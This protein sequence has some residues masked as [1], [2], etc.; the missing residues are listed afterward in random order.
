MEKA[1]ELGTVVPRKI[2]SLLL[3]SLTCIFR[4]KLNR[5]MQLQEL[6]AAVEKIVD[7]GIAQTPTM[8]VVKRFQEKIVGKL[9]ENEKG[10]QDKIL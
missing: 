7:R 5:N 1:K 3:F 9:S 8:T 4:F 2:F 6:M 10:L